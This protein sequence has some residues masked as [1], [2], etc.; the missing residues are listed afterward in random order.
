MF[1]RRFFF[2]ILL[3]LTLTVPLAVGYFF[4]YQNNGQNLVAEK[5]Y[6]ISKNTDCNGL[7]QAFD[8]AVLANDIKN[9]KLL[10]NDNSS[11]C[12]KEEGIKP[13]MQFYARIAAVEYLTDKKQ[14]AKDYAEKALELDR[15][16]PAFE[17]QSPN[18][19]SILIDMQ[20]IKQDQYQ[21]D[22]V[23]Y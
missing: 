3:P 22:G 18:Y 5:K 19:E 17:K 10:L 12:E 16:M 20:D 23:F 8:K 7:L 15:K 4:F 13:Q 2:Y 9:A 14:A 1:K 21:G 11:I 6:G